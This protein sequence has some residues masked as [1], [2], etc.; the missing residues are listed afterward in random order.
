VRFPLVRALRPLQWVK[1][2]FVL[3]PAVFAYGLLNPAVLGRAAVAFAAF[4]CAASA[5]YLVNDL[6]DREADRQHPLKRGRPIAAGALASGTAA[7]AA[8]GL[9]VAALVA[10]ALLGRAFVVVLVGYVA[11]T[12]VYSWRLKHVVIIDVMAISAGFLLRVEGGAVAV[13]AAVSSWLLL[14]TFFVSLFL[15]FSKRRHELALLAEGAAMQRRVLSHYGPAFLDQ[16]I[17]V[18]TASTVVSYALYASAP[19]TVAQHHGRALLLTLPMV[20]FGIFRYL[21]LIYQQPGRRNP[22]EEIFSDPPFL[23]NLVLWGAAVGWILYGR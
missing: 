13:G 15:A 19:E 20:L 10:A 16:M 1:N 23:A 9:A 18:V 21:F 22:T 6:H 11:L 4:C 5:G 3:A 17:N 7:A 8:A 12:L 2:A 14:C